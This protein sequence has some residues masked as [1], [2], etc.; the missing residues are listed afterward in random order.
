MYFICRAKAATFTFH[1][2]QLPV[3]NEVYIDYSLFIKMRQ[4]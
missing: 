2:F 1:T 3:N 4:I